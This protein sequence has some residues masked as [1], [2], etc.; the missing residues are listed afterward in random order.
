MTIKNQKTIIVGL[1]VA[2]IFVLLGVFCFSYA[3]ET[4]DKQAEELGAKEQPIYE[5]PFPDYSI[6]GLENEW[7]ALLIGIAGTL[8][9]FV[10]GLGV[11]KLLKKKKS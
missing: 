1:A 2:L 11:A 4:F 10:S 7:G 6:A 5:P 3:F 8:L 9:L